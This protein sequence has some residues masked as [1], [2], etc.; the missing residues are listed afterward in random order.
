MGFRAVALECWP[1]AGETACPQLRVK[2]WYQF[3]SPSRGLLHFW[4]SA[5]SRGNGII[6]MPFLNF[7]C[8]YIGSIL[9]WSDMVG[10]YAVV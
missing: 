7:A 6:R 4:C 10:L 2:L 1:N 3:Q 9:A 5:T 8:C